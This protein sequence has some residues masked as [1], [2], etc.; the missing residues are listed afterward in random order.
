MCITPFSGPILECG[1]T[2]VTSKRKLDSAP[3][4]L[5]IRAQV[6]PGLAHVGEQLFC[7]FA[8][9][10]LSDFPDCS[11]YDV[12]AASDREGHPMTDKVAGR[13]EGNV[14]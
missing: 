9:E 8:Y 7:V 14:S 1:R 6:V 3:S 2:T 4:Q 11:A 5:R 10:S 13:V 12:I